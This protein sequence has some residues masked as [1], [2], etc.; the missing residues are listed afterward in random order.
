VGVEGVRTRPP[1]D[2]HHRLPPPVVGELDLGFETLRL[3]DDP[4][5]WSPTRWWRGPRRADTAPAR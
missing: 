2:D 4:D 3:P 5:R 1:F